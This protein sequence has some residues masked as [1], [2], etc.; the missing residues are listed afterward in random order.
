MRSNRSE[1]E[2]LASQNYLTFISR[3]NTKADQSVYRARN[4][5]LPTCIAFG[6]TPETALGLL[7]EIRVA[8]IEYLLDSG[9]PVPRPRLFTNDQARALDHG[10]EYNP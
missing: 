5:E 4:Y 10:I 1:A 2:L 3:D 8:Y 6:D 7:R 9:V